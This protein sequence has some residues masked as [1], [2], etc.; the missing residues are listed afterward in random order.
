MHHLSFAS[1]FTGKECLA[2]EWRQQSGFDRA[3][4]TACAHSGSR[5]SPCEPF[6]PSAGMSIPSNRPHRP[7]E[8]LLAWGR[9]EAQAFDQL[10]PLVHEELRRLASRHMARERADHTLQASALVNEA[11]LRLIDLKRMQW[12]NRAHFFAMSARVMRRILVDFARAKRNEKRG[13]GATKVTLD[14]A[15]LPPK[16]TAYDLVALDDALHALAAV[17]PRKSE[18]V[19]LRYFGGLSLEET[20]E[21]LHVSIDTV[22]RDWRFAKLWLLRELGGR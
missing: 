8:L 13:G 3:L 5:M 9:G 16:E 11:Y 22:K 7:T 6:I 14:E 12:Q 17:H 1:A 15:L 2:L 20:A 10:V 19:E 4:S 18:V 21:A